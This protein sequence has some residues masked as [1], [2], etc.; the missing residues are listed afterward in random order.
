MHKKIVT[1][2]N[3]ISLGEIDSDIESVDLLNGAKLAREPSY[4]N[5]SL[6]ENSEDVYPDIISSLITLY[7]TKVK[8]SNQ[9]LQNYFSLSLSLHSI[10]SLIY[11]MFR[12]ISHS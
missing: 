6:S 1:L 9:I 5:I 7:S 3:N 10:E 11:I 8:A 2:D 4:I 12:E